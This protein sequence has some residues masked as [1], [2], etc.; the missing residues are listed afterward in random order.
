M[1][2][3]KNLSEENQYIINAIKIVNDFMNNRKFLEKQLIKNMPLKKVP[4]SLPNYYPLGYG[5]NSS[6]EN[7][8]AIKRYKKVKKPGNETIELI[9]N[10][11]EEN[12]QSDIHINKNKNDNNLII[13]KNVLFNI[14]EKLLKM[15]VV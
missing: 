9:N 1:T 10:I 13:N 14:D 5:I 2:K 6:L 11:E 3:S 7:Y 12:S 15:K 8:K 4:N